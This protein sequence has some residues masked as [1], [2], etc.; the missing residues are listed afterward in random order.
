MATGESK[1]SCTKE[2]AMAIMAK[3]MKIM[4]TD[5]AT[6]EAYRH[7]YEYFKAFDTACLDVAKYDKNLDEAEFKKL[8]HNDDTIFEDLTEI[9]KSIYDTLS[10]CLDHGEEVTAIKEAEEEKA[11]IEKAKKAEE[12]AK[13]A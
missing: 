2:D 11:N 5:E 9:Y 4:Q 10:K 6:K 3:A 8:L 12:A 13:L 7:G 1:N